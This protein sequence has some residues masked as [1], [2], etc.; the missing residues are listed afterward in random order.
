[1]TSGFFVLLAVQA[2]PPLDAFLQCF[3]PAAGGPQLPVNWKQ[4]LGEVLESKLDPEDID[5]LVRWL[6]KQQQ[7]V[8][9]L[10]GGWFLY[11]YNAVSV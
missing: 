1:M 5:F 8:D 4:Q 7:V 2:D 9:S 3:K 11:M 6:S 10:A